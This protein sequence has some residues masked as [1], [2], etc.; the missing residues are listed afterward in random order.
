MGEFRPVSALQRRPIY[1]P[2]GEYVGCIRDALFNPRDG[3]IEYVCIAMSGPASGTPA[4][5]IV[6]WSALDVTGAAG[7]ACSV[8][9]RKAALER[10]AVPIERRRG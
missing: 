3:R 7:D 10:I 9:A 5:A 6:P 8:S 1:D 4:E 2:T